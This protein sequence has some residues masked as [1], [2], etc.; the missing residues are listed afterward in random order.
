MQYLLYSYILINRVGGL[1]RGIFC[2]RSVQRLR[3]ERAKKDVLLRL[4]S[5]RH[6]LLECLHSLLHAYSTC[7]LK[8]SCVHAYIHT[9]KLIVCMEIGKYM[10][11]I[12]F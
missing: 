5:A 7:I 11:F 3:H 6:S 12:A 1:Y 4:F 2:P 9:G 10:Q 8:T